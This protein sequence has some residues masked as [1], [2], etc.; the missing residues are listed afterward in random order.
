[1]TDGMLYGFIKVIHVAGVIAW[2]G[3]ML[4]VSLVLAALRPP[5]QAFV[6]PERRLLQAVLTAN[7]RLVAPAM[8]IAWA[9]GLALAQGGHWFPAPWLMVK[10]S[11]VLILSAL[12]GI[13][14]GA[15]RRVA[16]Q[17]V[18]GKTS[19]LWTYGAPGVLALTTLIVGL[20]VLKPDGR[21]DP[22]AAT[23]PAQHQPAEEP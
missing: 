13:L 10:L 14:S 21:L 1:M 8:L 5:G 9:G 2:I 4:A 16:G 3:G 18:P 17:Q 7:R 19:P 23:M 11:L 12:H 22:R 6:L 20:V 15:L